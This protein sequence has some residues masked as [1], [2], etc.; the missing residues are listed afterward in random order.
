MKRYLLIM[1][2][3][4]WCG[5]TVIEGA[6]AHGNLR[7]DSRSLQAS[8]PIPTPDPCAT[9]LELLF[10]ADE[11][12]SVGQYNWEN[13]VIPAITDFVN[14][15]KVSEQ[16]TRFGI[17]TFG[18]SMSEKVSL[19]SS[20]STQKKALLKAIKD[21]KATYAGSGTNPLPTL[22]HIRDNELPKRRPGVPVIIPFMTDGVVE[23]A[24]EV[25]N[26]AAEIAR[27]EGVQFMCIEV[28]FAV[29]HDF[30]LALCGKEEFIFPVS[31][32]SNVIAAIREIAKAICNIA[33]PIATPTPTAMNATQSPT[34]SSPPP[35][36]V[37]W[38]IVF[39]IVGGV[40]IAAV[41]TKK[42]QDAKPEEEPETSVRHDIDGTKNRYV[43]KL[44]ITGSLGTMGSVSWTLPAKDK[45]VDDTDLAR[46]ERLKREAEAS[47]KALEAQGY[48]TRAAFLLSSPQQSSS[49]IQSAH[50]RGRTGASS[51]GRST[52]QYIIGMLPATNKPGDQ[53][54]TRQWVC[55]WCYKMCQDYEKEK[56]KPSALTPMSSKAAQQQITASAVVDIPVS[57]ASRVSAF[58]SNNSNNSNSKKTQQP[59]AAKKAPP[60]PPAIKPPNLVKV[61]P[62]P[63]PPP[64]QSTTSSAAKF[65]SEKQPK[66][67]QNPTFTAKY[68]AAATGAV[69]KTAPQKASTKPDVAS[70]YLAAVKGNVEDKGKNSSGKKPH[71]GM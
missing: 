1:M 17:Y 37:P 50:R 68:Q 15:F 12:G 61:P 71:S 13:F 23:N 31:S 4:A 53:E 64:K 2:Y 10:D 65:A 14:A 42:M 32:Y 69:Q 49:A 54:T 40:I 18:S 21:M 44:H 63:P 28:G 25:L 26:V 46:N 66:S 62:P 3:G 30:M 47:A 16:D 33:P 43:G 36:I 48:S 11:S 35:P 27:I 67:K 7:S 58:S 38:W 6:D 56:N 41:I 45:T 19:G 39:P 59:V 70:K 51:N 22:Q 55:C 52:I 60:P 5:L 57:V 29:D 24:P 9:K 20:K 34:E 8:T